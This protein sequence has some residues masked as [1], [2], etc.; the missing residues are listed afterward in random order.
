MR[1]KTG[2]TEH[3]WKSLSSAS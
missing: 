1:A 2:H 3:I